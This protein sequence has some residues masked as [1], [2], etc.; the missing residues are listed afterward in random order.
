MP[1]RNP[2]RLLAATALAALALCLSPAAQA[3]IIQTD[4]SFGTAGSVALGSRNSARALDVAVDAKDRPLIAS[5]SIQGTPVLSVQRTTGDG[6]PDATFGTTNGGLNY[7]GEVV[8]LSDVRPTYAQIAVQ[9]TRVIAATNSDTTP[10]FYVTRLT[11]EGQVDATFAT[12]GRFH[13]TTQ[14]GIGGV[15][16][17]GNRIYVAISQQEPNR[18]GIV[19]LTSDGRLDPS[20]GRGGTATLTTG[21]SCTATAVVETPKGP[22]LLATL[23]REGAPVARSGLLV[24]FTPAGALR[25]SF[26]TGGTVDFDDGELS[27]SA[28]A[29]WGQ[30]LVAT[31]LVTENGA[32]QL[33]LISR[34]LDGQ[35][36]TSFNGSV[37]LF[38]EPLPATPTSEPDLAVAG[39]G[40]LVVG[41]S[42]SRPPDAFGARAYGLLATAFSPAGKRVVQNGLGEYYFLPLK[43]TSDALRTYRG[44]LLASDTRGRVVA[45]GDTY[46]D[47]GGTLRAPA[48]ARLLVAS[49][50]AGEDAPDAPTA[51]TVAPNPLS[52]TARVTLTLEATAAARVTVLDAL[53]RTVAVL[54][55]GALPAGE[56]RLRLDAARLPA[57]VYA[58][59]A[60]AGGVRTVRR[61]T[62]VR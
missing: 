39:D 29:L 16:V 1:V 3:Q 44:S 59:V 13:Y 45:G 49:A 11:E 30:R 60:E 33:Y 17:A 54:A 61:V 7:A 52:A 9:D 22:V 23:V 28:L 10:G 51:L 2:A 48:L 25:T 42:A 57:G 15:A 34:T 40:S 47:N 62:V 14:V 24:G 31:G 4:A 8:P 21:P 26:G 55:D 43:T 6:Q 5:L 56:T 41:I 50:T 12:N 19:A 35:T 18:C 32:P 36:D 37:G 58:V 53:G 38:I 27:P 46:R 20:F